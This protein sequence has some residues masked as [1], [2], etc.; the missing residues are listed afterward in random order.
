V[1]EE[2]L[3][4]AS[5]AQEAYGLVALPVGQ[6]EGGLSRGSGLPGVPRLAGGGLLGV[7]LRAHRGLTPRVTSQRQQRLGGQLAPL[8][9]ELEGAAPQAHHLRA[10]RL[11]LLPGNQALDQREVELVLVLGPHGTRRVHTKSIRVSRECMNHP[12]F[13]TP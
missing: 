9:Q 1:R 11:E 12:P 8:Q 3:P 6:G 13:G 4:H 10:Q 2:H 7:A 5:L